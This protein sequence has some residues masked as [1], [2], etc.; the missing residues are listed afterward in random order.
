VIE[1]F[2][3]PFAEGLGVKANT[4]QNLFPSVCLLRLQAF[5]HDNGLLYER[6]SLVHGLIPPTKKCMG[7]SWLGVRYSDCWFN[8]FNTPKSMLA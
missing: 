6:V 3:W 1:T 4:A 8:E 7:C 2:F 5:S